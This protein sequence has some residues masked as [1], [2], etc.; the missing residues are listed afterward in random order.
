MFIIVPSFIGLI[1]DDDKTG[2]IICLLIWII[3]LLNAQ[4]LTDF[5]F[6]WK[7]FILAI[8]IIIGLSIMFKNNDKKI[9]NDEICSTFTNQNVN[10]INEKFN[11][12]N[13]D[14]IFGWVTLD[15]R[16]SKIKN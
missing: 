1:N 4:N 14:S 2:N 13:I 5:N 15:L 12:I 6:F 8:L 9:P 7:L 11:G 10:K 3:L 16:G